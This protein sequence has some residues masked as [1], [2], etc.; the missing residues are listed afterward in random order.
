MYPPSEEEREMF[1]TLKLPSNVLR[2]CR[3]CRT[4]FVHFYFPLS[5]SSLPSRPY[6]SFYTFGDSF[7]PI[8]PPGTVDINR[9]EELARKGID[10]AQVAIAWSLSKPGVT[11]PIVGT[12]CLDNLK[13]IIDTPEFCTFP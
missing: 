7:P 1:P 8:V 6:A 5:S 10:I 12:T 9:V 3:Y 2:L 13:D 11:A 4:R